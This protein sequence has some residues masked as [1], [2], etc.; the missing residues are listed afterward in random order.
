MV[1]VALVCTEPM[2]QG[3]DH[4]YHLTMVI[5]ERNQLTIPKQTPAY[6]VA[7]CG[8]LSPHTNQPSCWG[9]VSPHWKR[10][11]LCWPSARPVFVGPSDPLSATNNP[12]SPWQRDAD[13]P[14]LCLCVLFSQQG[15]HGSVL[16]HIMCQRV[17]Q[18]TALLCQVT[19]QGQ[20][21][22]ERREDGDVRYTVWAPFV[23]PFHC[24]TRPC[25]LRRSLHC[26]GTPT[27][28]TWRP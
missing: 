6:C 18:G 1:T 28:Q 3:N 26:T 17:H 27:Q 4:S 22:G 11:R 7:N 9:H 24:T 25:V 2:D 14:R 20:R 23:L 5:P 13:G 15:L 19:G 16:S 21:L 8:G 10:S 12:R